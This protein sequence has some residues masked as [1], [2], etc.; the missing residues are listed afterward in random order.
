MTNP[1]ALGAIEA[2]QM[3]AR[4]QLSPV[5]LAEDLLQRLVVKVEP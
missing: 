5:E 2:R 3:I 4:K 1:A